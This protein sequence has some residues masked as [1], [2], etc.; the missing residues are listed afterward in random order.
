MTAIV[1]RPR[2]AELPRVAALS[3]G[4]FAPETSVRA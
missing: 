4:N 1:G 3:E 2:E